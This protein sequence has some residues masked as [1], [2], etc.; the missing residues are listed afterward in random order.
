MINT[1]TTKEVKII[2]KI[3]HSIL[4]ANCIKWELELHLSQKKY[5]IFCF[6]H[7]LENEVPN[8]GKDLNINIL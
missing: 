6:D 7:N 5:F 3:I 2:A 4:F 1:G 8:F